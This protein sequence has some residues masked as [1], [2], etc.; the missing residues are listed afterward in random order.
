MRISDWS[1]DVCSSDL[2]AK[3]ALERLDADADRM[4]VVS[5]AVVAEMLVDEGFLYAEETV[6]AM[7]GPRRGHVEHAPLGYADMGDIIGKRPEIFD[8]RRL[9]GGVPVDER[10]TIDQGLCCHAYAIIAEPVEA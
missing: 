8:F 10:Y 6:G 9:E 2:T 5:V 1:S 3:I 4:K 7:A